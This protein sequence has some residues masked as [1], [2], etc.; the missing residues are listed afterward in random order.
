MQCSVC[1]LHQAPRIARPSTLKNQMG[2]NDK[3]FVDGISWTNP[4]GQTF[5][6]YHFLDAGTNY[7]VGIAEPNRSA[8]ALIEHILQGWLLWAGSPHELIMDAATEFASKEFGSFLR[9]FN[10]KGTCVPPGAHW[11]VG[12]SE[13]HGAILQGMLDK[14]DS[15]FPI[16]S[17]S[18]LQSALIHSSQAMNACSRKY[19]YAP[20]VLVFGK[21]RSSRFISWR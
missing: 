8:S 18:E 4:R 14:Y 5:H 2:F 1:Q 21:M 10:I 7:H 17:Y 20:E 9:Q 15:D 19:G 11:Q 12:K 6:F 3:V 13:R 16:N